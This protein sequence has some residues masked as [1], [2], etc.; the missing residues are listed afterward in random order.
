MFKVKVRSNK[1]TKSKCCLCFV[2]HTF[3]WSF[4]TPN[5]IM[6]FN[7]KFDPMKGKLQVKL[8]QIGSTFK[9]Q[10]FLTKICLSCADFLRIPQMSF[11]FMYNN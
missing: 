6:T 5:S 10:H 4:G 8:G 9:I 2:R 3:Y 7:L 11:I 1:V